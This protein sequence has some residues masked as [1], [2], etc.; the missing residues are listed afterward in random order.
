MTKHG[1]FGDKPAEVRVQ[2]DQ[3]AWSGHVISDQNGRFFLYDFWEVCNRSLSIQELRCLEF[4]TIWYNLSQGSNLLCFQYRTS[5]GL[6]IHIRD[7]SRNTYRKTGLYSSK[8]HGLAERDILRCCKQLLHF[9]G[10]TQKTNTKFQSISGF[11]LDLG[12]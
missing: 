10:M 5:T 9:G 3:V 1:T 12:P 4:L 6:S 2:V 8:S 11:R 7:F